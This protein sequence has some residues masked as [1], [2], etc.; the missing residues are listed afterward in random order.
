MNICPSIMR[1]PDFGM[2]F[3]KDIS[4]RLLY[5]YESKDTVTI[6]NFFDMLPGVQIRE[7][8]VDSKLDQFLNFFYDIFKQGAGSIG[9]IGEMF[10]SWDKFKSKV[11]N[12]GQALKAVKQFLIG[13]G[14]FVNGPNFM[15]D[16]NGVSRWSEAAQGAAQGAAAGAVVGGPV[17][18]L[19]G[20]A[21]GA[22]A[23]KPP[24][25]TF[26]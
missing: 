4:N 19:V 1:T 17:G 11:G 5:G 7:F 13:E 21:A 16:K 22:A 24:I 8:Q 2:Y 26:I 23:G 25:D 12:I 6:D 10:S 3:N 9:D 18:A 20:A 14:A 15:V